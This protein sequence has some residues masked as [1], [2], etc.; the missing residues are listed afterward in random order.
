MFPRNCHVRDTLSRCTKYLKAEKILE[1]VSILYLI[2]C[3]LSLQKDAN[4][5]LESSNNGNII[6]PV[7]F[8]DIMFQFHSY[9]TNWDKI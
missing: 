8:F 7:Q 3:L 2:K 9:S 1:F 6:K 4:C 5:H